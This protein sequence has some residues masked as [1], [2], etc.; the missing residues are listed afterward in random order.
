[1]SDTWKKIWSPF[2]Y[3][4]A[5]GEASFREIFVQ[6]GISDEDIG[7]LEVDNDIIMFDNI[8]SIFGEIKH[9][10][11]VGDKFAVLCYIVLRKKSVK[12][13]DLD[14]IGDSHVVELSRVGDNRV[15]FI[16]LDDYFEVVTDSA[17]AELITDSMQA[18]IDELGGIGVVSSFDV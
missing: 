10:A 12:I 1:M 6:L 7:A 16:R 15:V 4:A 5:L 3:D 9:G 14:D 18:M 11:D 13:C 2:A 17:T 8:V